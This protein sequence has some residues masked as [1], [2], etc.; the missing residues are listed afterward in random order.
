FIMIILFSN[1]LIANSDT[2]KLL[3]ITVK[4]QTEQKVVVS[5]RK[6][7][8]AEPKRAIYKNAQMKRVLK[9][10]KIKRTPQKETAYGLKMGYKISKNVS[11]SV[12]VLA[13]VDIKNSRIKSKEANLQFAFSI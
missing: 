4:T 2:H 9:Y 13:E 7:R 6:K 11:V 3:G 1:T 5:D 10:T 8:Y 12:D